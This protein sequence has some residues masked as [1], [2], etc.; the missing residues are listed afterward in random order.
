MRISGLKFRL[1][2]EHFRNV[3][4]QMYL[5]GISETNGVA[6]HGV[7][8][9]QIIQQSSSMNILLSARTNQY[10]DVLLFAMILTEVKMQGRRDTRST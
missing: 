7:S 8:A 4:R 9:E 2:E 6:Y 5:P 1:N 10:N 3:N